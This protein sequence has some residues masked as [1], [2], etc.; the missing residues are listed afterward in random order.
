MKYSFILP[1]RNEEQGIGICI[2]KIQKTMEKLFIPKKEYEIIVSDSSSDNSPK[3]AVLLG[4]KLVKHDKYG[5]GN[6]YIEGFKAASGEILIMGDA[7]DT[8]DFQE[9][10]KLLPYIESYDLVLGKR[11]YIHNKAMPFLNRYIGNPVLSGILRL[12]FGAKVKDAHTGLRI[13][14]RK[15]F[16]SLNLRTTGMEFASEM[17]IKAGKQNLKIKEIPIHYYKR[18]GE[19]KL[20]R[21]PDGWRHLRFM[22]LYSPMYLFFIPGLILFLL[23]MISMLML[24]FDLFSVLGIKL[25]YHPMFLSALLI[26]A[27]YQIMIFSAFAK[28][29]AITHLGERSY[30][31]ENLFRLVSIEKASIF[32]LFILFTGIFI[33]VKIF[34]S[35]V[36]SGLGNLNEVKNSIVALTLILLSLQTIFSSFMLSMLG[37]KEK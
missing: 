37:I 8:Y 11:E 3:I 10:P 27:G 18:K 22:L 6:A 1:C 5:Y 9:V 2:T 25:Y 17:I 12:F 29:Y 7:D 30:F 28:T 20:R 16:E 31:M 14:K 26:I 36:S 21:I 35:W 23:G 13:I 34:A 15:T 19:T 24:Y 4:A 32:G 33:Y